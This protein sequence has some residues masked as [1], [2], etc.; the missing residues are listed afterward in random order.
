[1]RKAYAAAEGTFRS[2]CPAREKRSIQVE[3]KAGQTPQSAGDLLLRQ[4]E[5]LLQQQ[6][7]QQQQQLPLK[8]LLFCSFFFGLTVGQCIN[9][10]GGKPGPSP[11]DVAAHSNRFG[12]H[13]P[14][15]CCGNSVQ[16]QQQQQQ[17]L[18]LQLQLLQRAR[19]ID[20]LL[21]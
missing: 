21:L 1:M 18:Q 4:V 16:Q 11:I 8:A 13:L 6:P 2:L 7:R 15:T 10:Y 5:Q 19:Q 17:Q 3:S 14:A 9:A 20:L 12:T